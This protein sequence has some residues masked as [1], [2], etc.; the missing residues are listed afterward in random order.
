VSVDVVDVNDTPSFMKRIYSAFVPE[1]VAVGAVVITVAVVD[2]DDRAG[3]K[4]TYD[5][6][7]EGEASGL[8]AV[9]HATGR[10]ITQRALTG[11]GHT[12]PFHLPVRAQDGGNPSLSTD[13]QLSIFIGDVFTNDGVPF[14]SRPALNEVAKISEVRLLL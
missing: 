7:N 5:L 2:P 4:I 1:N 11:K 9:N 6:S 10:I 13:M 12:E 14:S 8:F 3:G